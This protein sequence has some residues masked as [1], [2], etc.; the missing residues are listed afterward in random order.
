MSLDGMIRILRSDNGRD[1]SLW[2]TLQW[3]GGDLR[4]PKLAI[5]KNLLLMSVGIR[6]AVPSQAEKQ[7]T[8]VSWLIDGDHSLTGPFGFSDQVKDWRWAPS[9]NGVA[10]YSV[11]YG[12]VNQSGS[13]SFSENGKEWDVINNQFF[14][15]SDYFSNEASLVFTNNRQAL[16]LLRR[17]GFQSDAAFGVSQPPYN[18]WSWSDTGVRIGGPKLFQLTSGELIAVGRRF[19]EDDAVTSIFAVEMEGS[20]FW[21]MDLTSSGDTSYPGVVEKEGRL[22][23]SYY[24]SHED[25]TGIYLAEVVFQP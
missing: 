1:W 5:G 14:P 4:D 6:W 23:I 8:T 20:M 10:F 11:G 21:Q 22:W 24:S 19:T 2:K 25:I 18:Q 12:I 15:P 3:Q 7:L 9:W 13:L 16:C 17:D